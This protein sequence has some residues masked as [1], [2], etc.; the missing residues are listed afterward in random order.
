MKNTLILAL[1][2]VVLAL[3]ACAAPETPASTPKPSTSTIE[4]VV[5]DSDVA[6]D[7][8]DDTLASIMKPEGFHLSDGLY[9]QY[10]VM[11]CEG[12]DDGLD[13][14]TIARIGE[15]SFGRYSIEQH[16]TMVGAS[17]GSLCPEHSDTVLSYY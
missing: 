2:G 14:L 15:E 9:Y 17:V 6:A 1:G 8:I 4:P 5:A 16:A 11:V 3:G 13:P 12:L 7:Q 10:A